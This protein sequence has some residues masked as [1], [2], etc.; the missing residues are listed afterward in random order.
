V[1]RQTKKAGLARRRDDRRKIEKGC[2]KDRVVLDDPDAAGLFN[3]VE[4]LRLGAGLRDEDGLRERGVAARRC[5]VSRTCWA[6]APAASTRQR[7]A[8]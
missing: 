5:V 8:E 4:A 3:N 6:V 2:R 7:A 1:K